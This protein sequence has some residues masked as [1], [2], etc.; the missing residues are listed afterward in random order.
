MNQEL[1]LWIF[2][3]VGAWLIMLSAA[4]LKVI[5]EQVKT[6]VAVDLFIDTLGEKIAKALHADDDHH[7]L[8]ALLDKYLK[9]DYELSY[10]E[11]FELKN[12]C[13]HILETKGCTDIDRSLSGMLAAVCEHKLIVKYGKTK[14]TV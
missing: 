9:R 3:I 12:R 4:L 7:H 11:W 1:Q 5:I 13:N 8:D 10:E 14:Q 6:K 2:G